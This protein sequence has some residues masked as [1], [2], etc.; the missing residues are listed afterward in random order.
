MQLARVLS[1]TI[2]VFWLILAQQPW[3]VISSQHGTR[4]SSTLLA[5]LLISSYIFYDSY[6]LNIYPSHTYINFTC[7]LTSWIAGAELASLSVGIVRLRPCIGT[8]KT[9]CRYRCCH[10]DRCHWCHSRCHHRNR[11]H[12]LQHH[13]H[14][15]HHNHQDHHGTAIVS[16]ILLTIIIINALGN[17]AAQVTP[18]VDVRIVS[19]CAF[20]SWEFR[21]MWIWLIWQVHH[22]TPTSFWRFPHKRST[23]K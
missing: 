12:H 20:F 9:L 1:L 16:I 21:T 22:P 2:I 4:I 19:R 23:L 7:L 5:W 15:L 8:E 17:S 14:C 13:H 3:H 10:T 6:T 18:A 11:F